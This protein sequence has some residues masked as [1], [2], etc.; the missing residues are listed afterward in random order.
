MMAATTM[1][2]GMIISSVLSLAY[3]QIHTLHLTAD[4]F[5]PLLK[6]IVNRPGS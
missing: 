4:I 5:K 2:E 3:P 6:F 1:V